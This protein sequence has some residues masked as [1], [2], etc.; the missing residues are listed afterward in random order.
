MRNAR[1]G[2]FRKERRR[3]PACVDQDVTSALLK[4]FR[5]P[6]ISETIHARAIEASDLKFIADIRDN[7]ARAKPAR[8]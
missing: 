7:S 8:M 3:E 5:T 1:S 4:F 2:S 6:F